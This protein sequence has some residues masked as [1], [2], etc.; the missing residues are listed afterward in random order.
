MHVSWLGFCLSAMVACG[1]GSVCVL[2]LP[3]CARRCSTGRSV[4]SRAFRLARPRVFRSVVIMPT[5]AAGGRPHESGRLARQAAA[6]CGGPVPPDRDH[7]QDTR[8]AQQG[9][10]AAAA[11]KGHGVL[12]PLTAGIAARAAL[13]EHSGH[14]KAAI[15]RM[16]K[17]LSNG[18]KSSCNTTNRT[19][20]V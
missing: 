2:L 8:F 7:A 14:A 1:R 16:S 17:R 11:C 4:G 13:A 12:V 10:A 5:T 15:S 18:N 9:V 19:A 6:Q 3:V 20:H